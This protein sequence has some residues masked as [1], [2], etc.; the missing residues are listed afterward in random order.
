[1]SVPVAAVAGT[2]LI[3]APRPARTA[4][5]APAPR[6]EPAAVASP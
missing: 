6:R 3:A 4:P 1:M 2:F 5:D